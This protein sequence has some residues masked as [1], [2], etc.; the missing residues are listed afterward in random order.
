MKWEI[1]YYLTEQAFKN[2]NAA[3]KETIS[4]DRNYAVNWVNNKLK[5]SN[6]KFYDIV[7][8]EELK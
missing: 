5:H 2:K 4:G 6:F 1:R 7:Q 8:K 3:F